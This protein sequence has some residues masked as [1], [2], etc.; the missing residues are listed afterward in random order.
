[1]SEMSTNGPNAVLE[2]V[3]HLVNVEETWELSDGQLLQLYLGQHSQE[4]FTMLLRRHERLVW[5]VCRCVL[6]CRQDA[7]DA[8]QATFVVL[9]R[10]AAS[11]AVP[12]ALGGWLC[13]VAYR[14]ALQARSRIVRRHA[15]EQQMRDMPDH[16]AAPENGWP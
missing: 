8:F 6:P 10:K 4:A 7:E 13:R 3:C 5:N 1:M 9:A 2:H 16:E 14:T 15:R 11:V 12:N